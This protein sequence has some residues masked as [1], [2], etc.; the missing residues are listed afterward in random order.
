MA[1]GD[2]GPGQGVQFLLADSGKELIEFISHGEKFS[3][4]DVESGSPQVRGNYNERQTR[5]W[6]TRFRSD[7]HDEDWWRKQPTTNSLNLLLR[8]LEAY[9]PVIVREKERLVAK[10]EA[11]EDVLNAVER[12]DL[13]VF[14]EKGRTKGRPTVADRQLS[15]GINDGDPAAVAA[16][17]AAGADVHHPPG[18]Q[19]DA[20]EFA[21]TGLRFGKGLLPDRLAVVELLL[22][23]GAGSGLPADHN[24]RRDWWRNRKHAELSAIYRRYWK[25]NGEEPELDLAAA[26]VG[27]QPR[28]TVARRTFNRWQNLR[29]RNSQVTAL[30]ALGFER[31]GDFAILEWPALRM[32]VLHHPALQA[33]ATLSEYALL[34]WADVIRWHGDG[35]SLLVS[36]LDLGPQT[37][38]STPRHQKVFQPRWGVSKLVEFTKNEPVPSGG[39]RSV[40]PTDFTALFELYS[41]EELVIPNVLTLPSR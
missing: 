2:D 17:L 6:A 31:L 7:R 15:Q 10:V 32:C 22:D 20:L 29:R 24:A 26:K 16:A 36:N 18:V 14:G 37:V 33:F 4:R 39:I 25:V 9:L 8:E 38:L 27:E 35:S 40:A 13:L 1:A 28:V 21:L 23:A 34:S 41:A 19:G 11:D 30:E 12:I 3:L 5:Q